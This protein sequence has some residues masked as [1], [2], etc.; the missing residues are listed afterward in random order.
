M[1][2][3]IQILMGKIQKLSVNG[4]LFIYLFFEL[5]SFWILSWFLK[6]SLKD[7][8][9]INFTKPNSYFLYVLEHDS[10]A[11]FLWLESWWLDLQWIC[12]LSILHLLDIWLTW[13]LITWSLMNL[14]FVDFAFA[15]YLIDHVGPIKSL[16]NII[17]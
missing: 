17:L 8:I 15:W 2:W 13:V 10:W 6:L 5:V 3:P 11:W 7:Q 12:I 4:F 16:V 9:L 14:H 1:V